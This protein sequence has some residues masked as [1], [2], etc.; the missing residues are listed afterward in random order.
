MCLRHCMCMGADNCWFPPLKQLHHSSQRAI[1]HSC[2]CVAEIQSPQHLLIA[3]EW[4]QTWSY[5]RFSKKKK[6]KKIYEVLE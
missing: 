1:R 4:P 2:T 3:L 5:S 6:K